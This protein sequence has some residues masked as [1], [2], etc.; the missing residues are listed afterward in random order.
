MSQLRKTTSPSESNETPEQ[1]RLSVLSR[2]KP[3]SLL[4]PV[5][6]GCFWLAVT[7]PYLYV[8]L[9]FV[10]IDTALRGGVFLTLLVLN[11]VALLVGHTYHEPTTGG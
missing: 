2:V 11:V 9:L 8:P 6:R 3:Q 7:V 1:S 5:Q 4:G 10:G